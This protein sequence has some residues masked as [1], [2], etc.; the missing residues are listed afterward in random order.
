M[1]TLFYGSGFGQD[2]PPEYHRA[3]Q[4]AHPVPRAGAGAQPSDLCLSCVW[5][6]GSFP[7][8]DLGSL[9]FQ[10]TQYRSAFKAYLLV[11]SGFFFVSLGPFDPLLSDFSC[12]LD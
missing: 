8:P 3:T 1:Q 7:F 2:F 12:L 11:F 6:W 9:R 5:R 10:S 4:A